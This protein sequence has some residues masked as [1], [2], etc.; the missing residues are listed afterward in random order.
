[1]IPCKDANALSA[2][3][4]SSHDRAFKLTFIHSLAPLFSSPPLVLP[5]VVVVGTLGP[6]RRASIKT[7]I[8]IP[9]AVKIDTIIIPCSLKGPLFFHQVSPFLYPRILLLIL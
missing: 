6:S 9:T 3:L 4:P 8:A 7:P 1:M 2:N 5:D